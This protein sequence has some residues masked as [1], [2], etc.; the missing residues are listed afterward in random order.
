MSD[1]EPQ[2]LVTA[3][4]TCII[5]HRVSL[6]QIAK[7]ITTSHLCKVEFYGEKAWIMCT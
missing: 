2:A 3:N 6:T 7:L 4:N 5:F 1:E